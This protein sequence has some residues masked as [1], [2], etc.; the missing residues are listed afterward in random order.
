LIGRLIYLG[1]IYLDIS[2]TL[3]VVSHYMYDPR[4]GHINAVYHI[5]R[6]LKSTSW[7]G[8]IFRKNKHM[9]IEGYCDSDWASCQDDKRSTSDYCIFIRGNLVS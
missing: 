1:H 4:K 3:S 6:Y 9:K 7:K 8:L 5:L 2:F